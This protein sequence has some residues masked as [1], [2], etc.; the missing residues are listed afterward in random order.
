MPSLPT[1]PELVAAGIVA[2]HAVI[3]LVPPPTFALSINYRVMDS[4]APEWVWGASYLV[5]VAIW[6]L[7]LAWRNTRARQVMLSV[8]AIVIFWMGASFFLSNI[9]TTIGYTLL[10]VGAG[11]FAAR[12]GM[13]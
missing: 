8:L 1:I 13:R 3:F 9:N 2:A 6:V 10:I 11:T 4:V 7:A 12:V 5:I